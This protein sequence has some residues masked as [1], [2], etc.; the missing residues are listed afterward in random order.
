MK[1]ALFTILFHATMTYIQRCDDVIIDR[2]V[3][4]IGIRCNRT[5]L[6]YNRLSSVMSKVADSQPEKQGSNPPRASFFLMGPFLWVCF[7]T[8]L[9]YCDS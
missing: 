2:S 4:V 1:T 7:T 5:A 3:V 6:Q 9:L 8:N